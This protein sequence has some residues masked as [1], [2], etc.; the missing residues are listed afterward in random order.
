[1]INALSVILSNAKNLIMS[2]LLSNDSF[3][4]NKVLRA[5][6]DDRTFHLLP[7]HFPFPSRTFAPRLLASAAAESAK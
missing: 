5:A 2:G 3:S 1:M 4:R 7:H 6:Q